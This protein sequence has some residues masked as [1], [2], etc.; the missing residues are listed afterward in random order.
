L[1]EK[2]Q[3]IKILSADATYQKEFS[4]FSNK[5]TKIE[6]IS[7]LT[8]AEIYIIVSTRRN[9]NPIIHLSYLPC[10]YFT[11]IDET[12]KINRKLE[13]N[14][15]NIEHYQTDRCSFEYI[16]NSRLHCNW[17]KFSGGKSMDEFKLVDTT[18]QSSVI[19]S[20]GVRLKHREVKYFLS[21]IGNSE[22]RSNISKAYI[23]SPIFHSTDSKTAIISFYH[24]M[25]NGTTIKAYIVPKNI[26][27]LNFIVNS[28]PAFEF[29]KEALFWNFT[30]M[31]VQIPENFS[32]FQVVLE[33]SVSNSEKCGKESFNSLSSTVGIDELYVH[34]YY[35]TCSRVDVKTSLLDVNFENNSYGLWRRKLWTIYSNKT[36]ESDNKNL[37]DEN[38]QHILGLDLFN[39]ASASSSSYFKTPFL[40]ANSNCTCQISFNYFENNYEPAL[41]LI[42]TIGLELAF[43][44]RKTLWY[45][46]AA[47]NSWRNS[48][49]EIKL[50]NNNRPFV[51]EFTSRYLHEETKSYTYIDNIRISKCDLSLYIKPKNKNE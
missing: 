25:C 33:G 8:L 10:I 45:E 42:Q 26:D 16:K 37:F 50:V 34:A 3:K 19:F 17:W 1:S 48:T 7:L 18:H 24:I 4:I 28:K 36:H 30:K 41:V 14:F 11:P 38:H 39:H 40:L 23:V 44:S 2:P 13:A 35:Q 6:D 21:L 15:L 12:V 20:S 51:L 46:S 49:V 5:T 43:T 9:S 27:F 32:H 47:T 29:K 22:R 31:K